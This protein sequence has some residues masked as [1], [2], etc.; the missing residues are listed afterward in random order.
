MK[1][2]SILNLYHIILGLCS[3]II[4]FFQKLII[5]AFILLVIIE[6]IGLHKKDFYFKKPNRISVAFILLYVSYFIGTFFTFFPE[7]ANKYLEYKLS[8]F[9]IPLLFLI[10]PKKKINLFYPTLGLILGLILSLTIGLF[11]ATICYSKINYFFDCYFSS[12]LT[13]EHPTYYT[14]FL[15]F[16]LA[17]IW[18]AYYLKFKFF[19]LANSIILT[20][21]FIIII[22]LSL[23][24]AGL[25]FLLISFFLLLIIFVYKKFGKIILL[26]SIFISISIIFSIMVFVPILKDEVDNSKNALINYIK[27]PNEFVKMNTKHSGDDVRLIM[28]TVTFDGFLD[29][30][31]GVGTGN[32]DFYL[33]NKLK[34]YNQYDLGKMDNK[35]QILYNPHN[36]FLQTGLEIGIFGLLILLF[37]I[38]Y[39]LK[40]AY[41][42][43]N[44]ILFILLLNLFF[45]SLFESMLQRQS[46]IVF[47]TFWICLL[48]VYAENFCQKSTKLINEN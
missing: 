47:Y 19:S 36:Q 42:T 3:F 25:L 34:N 41:Q 38:F 35:H 27:D 7:I 37:I 14:V 1:K 2:L 22:I 39:G 23:A 18:Q 29:H 15:T 21:V 13:T 11:N 4:V 6:L 8:F 32:L 12:N 16:A 33:S 9:L 44:W 17:L 48:S 43:K 5:I 31:F 10:Q 20:L 28:W 24:M 45:N 46:G 30:P 40:K 26:I